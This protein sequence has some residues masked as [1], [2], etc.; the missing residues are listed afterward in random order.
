MNIKLGVLLF[1]LFGCS[2]ASQV[3]FRHYF[4]DD[5]VAKAF[6]ELDK[7]MVCQPGKLIYETYTTREVESIELLRPVNILMLGPLKIPFRLTIKAT[8][9]VK[10]FEA[11]EYSYF[12]APQADTKANIPGIKMVRNEDIIGIRISSYG[13]LE[14]YVDSSVYNTDHIPRLSTKLVSKK[15]LLNLVHRKKHVRFQ[16]Q[17]MAGVI[18]LYSI[19]AAHIKLL[20]RRKEIS[21]IH[22]FSRSDKTIS[23]ARGELKILAID[24]ENQLKYKWLRLPKLYRRS[25]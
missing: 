17:E 20:V 9:L 22:T 11:G 25:L 15:S 5:L 1:T 3:G 4:K 14:W 24:P 13:V 19:S 10:E 16:K 2:C 23:I 6:P 8:N 21:E 7:E 12:V 18:E